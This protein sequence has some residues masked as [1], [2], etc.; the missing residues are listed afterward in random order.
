MGKIVVFFLAVCWLQAQAATVMA[1][2][3]CFGYQNLQFEPAGERLHV[4]QN[5]SGEVFVTSLLSGTPEC[6]KALTIA[7]FSVTNQNMSGV[8]ALPYAAGTYFSSKVVM[9]TFPSA[10]GPRMALHAGDDLSIFDLNSL[11]V[12]AAVTWD[13]NSYPGGANSNYLKRVFQI[14]DSRYSMTGRVTDFERNG[15]RYLSIHPDVVDFKNSEIKFVQSLPDIEGTYS[16]D[17][18]SYATN[19]DGEPYAVL[20]I[21]NYMEGNDFPQLLKS[22]SLN[23]GTI[24]ELTLPFSASAQRPFILPEYV[25]INGTK[26][27]AVRAPETNSVDFYSIKDLK[28]VKSLPLPAQSDDY[29]RS[30]DIDTA[31]RSKLLLTTYR[32]D[33]LGKANYSH[34]D[35]YD[36]NS[37]TV[38]HSYDSSGA[39]DLCTAVGNRFLCVQPATSDLGNKIDIYDGE[40]GA[41]LETVYLPHEDLYF[42]GIGS[43]GGKLYL[44]VENKLLVY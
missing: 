15:K 20:F 1:L 10:D 2:P 9:R 25:E 43:V 33:R 27:V 34:V 7:N 28:L 24:A 30:V 19:V 4:W 18:D 11:T 23:S 40:T 12:Q 39:S 29:G 6:S 17:N 42:A 14:G 5:D 21:F 3:P 8:T 44:S 26:C 16:L 38:A 41:V 13:G 32:Y 31:N 22:V 37:L 35:V 36:L